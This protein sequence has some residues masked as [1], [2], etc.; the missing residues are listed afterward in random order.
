M[1][2][3]ELFEIKLTSSSISFIKKDSCP[4]M[5][6]IVGWQ[7]YCKHLSLKHISDISMIITVKR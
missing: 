5:M 2:N 3:S 4:R 1:V 7:E 6:H